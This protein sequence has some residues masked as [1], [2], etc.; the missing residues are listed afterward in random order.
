M[1]SVSGQLDLAPV[2]S[3]VHYLGDQATAVG[4]NEN[5]RKT[6]YLCRSVYLPVIRN[7]LPEIFEAFDFTDAHATTGARPRTSVPTQTL[8]LLNDASVLSAA[9]AL[10]KR[11]LDDPS[12]ADDTVRID[13]LFQLLFNAPPTADERADLLAFIETFEPRDQAW[14]AAAHAMLS[15]SRFQFLD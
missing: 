7:D 12:L 9:D 2:E 3:T 10:S 13:R 4:K 6:D 11:L 14:P 1:L 15:T 8:F 5:R